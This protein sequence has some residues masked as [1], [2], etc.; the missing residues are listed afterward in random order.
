MPLPLWTALPFAV[1]LLVIALV[2]LLAPRFWHPNRNKL[3]LALVASLPVA[4]YLLLATEHGGPWLAHSLR[5]YAGFIALM[6]ALYV[7]AGG[8]YLRG[9]SAGNTLILG[10]GAVIASF[11]GTTGASMILVRPLLRANEHRRRRAH[12][13][14][15]FIFIVSNAGGLLTPMG[16]PPLFLGFLHGVPFLWTF[17]LWAPWLLVNGVLLAVFAVV[18][19]VML[20]KEAPSPAK[21]RE[22][23]RIEGGLNFLW[24]AGVIGIV[25]ATGAWG[26]A[27][28]RHSDAIMLAQFLGLAIVTMLSLMTTQKSVRESN[29]FTWGPILEV[30]AI[31]VGIFVT[32]VPALQI[33]AAMGAD[34]RIAVTEPRQYFWATGV[35]S[36]FLDNAPTYLTFAALAAGQEGVHPLRLGDLLNAGGAP[37]LAAISCA[38]VFFGAMTYIGNGPNFMVKAIAEDHG[39]A[40]PGFF[41]YMAWSAAI[42]LPLFAVVSLIWF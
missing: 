16:D 37:L 34:G 29:R 10:T 20:G 23:L 42:L 15:F 26:P 33:L 2:P 1:Y 6:A 32:M 7:T 4:V 8:I 38:A 13:V 30:A 22:P 36:S 17:R 3:I 14:V 24:L 27:L 28:F 9:S 5:D 19:R 39:V 35:L 41:G 25:Y 11:I 18:D 12:V 21:V 40:M 31:F